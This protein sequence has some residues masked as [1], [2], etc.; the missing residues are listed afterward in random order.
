[1][2]SVRLVSRKRLIGSKGR[3]ITL[4]RGGKTFTDTPLLAFVQPFLLNRDL[5]NQQLQQGDLHIHTLADITP[6]ATDKVLIDGK[7]LGIV[8]VPDAVY[9]G[10]T[11]I[12]YGFAVRGT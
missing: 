8:G 10:E 5:P 3:T 6:V 1:M 9:D 2:V 11:L 4:R 7:V 12:G